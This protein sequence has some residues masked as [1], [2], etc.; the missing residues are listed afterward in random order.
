MKR[1]CKAAKENLEEVKTKTGYDAVDEDQS[2]ITA[3]ARK[4]VAALQQQEK[5]E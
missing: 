2:S 3:I 4:L 1:A 5:A